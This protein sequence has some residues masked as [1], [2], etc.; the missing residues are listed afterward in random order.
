ML[1]NLVVKDYL[2]QLTELRP[3]LVVAKT[4][5]SLSLK[6]K[7]N[8]ISIN[9]DIIDSCDSFISFVLDI[10]MDL[11]LTITIKPISTYCMTM[12]VIVKLDINDLAVGISPISY[13]VHLGIFLAYLDYLYNKEFN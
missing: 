12:M 11:D 2:H 3:D 9:L 8:M 5:S 10:L 13:N 6:Y 4:N 7:E 1:D